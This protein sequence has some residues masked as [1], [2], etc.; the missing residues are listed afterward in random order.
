MTADQDLLS[1]YVRGRRDAF[2][3]LWDRHG[4]RVFGVALRV[5]GDRLVA[6]EVVQE[7]FCLL[8][9][10]AAVLAGHPSP[11]GWLHRTA[12]N[13]AR[14]LRRRRIH[15]ERKLARFAAE[16]ALA[17]IPG[18]APEPAEIDFAIS[19]LPAD[20][21]D[22]VVQRFYDGADYA[23]IGD[24]LGIS[25]AAARKRLSRALRRLQRII[26]PRKAA[27]LSVTAP[28]VA[29]PPALE[30]AV[31]SQAAAGA[32]PA[33]TLT[34]LT[35]LM[36]SKPIAATAAALI[37]TGGLTWFSIGTYRENR[38][39]RAV[40]EQQAAESAGTSR[41]A[42][43]GGDVAAGPDGDGSSAAQLAAVRAELEEERTRRE[44][45]ERQVGDLRRVADDLSDEVVVSFGRVTDIGNTLGSAFTEAMALRDLEEKGQLDTPENQIRFGKFFRSALSISGLSQELIEFEDNPEEGSRFVGAVYGTVFGLSDSERARVES[46]FQELLAEAAERELTLSHLP[47]PGTEEFGPWMER[48]WEFFNGHRDALRELLP[49]GSHASFDKWV[50]KG[51]YGFRNLK[52]KGMPFMFSLGG[53]PR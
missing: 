15:H 38:R 4:G 36:T 41:H 21:R 40:L 47:E 46:S 35:T 27:A 49:A 48:R 17:E 34:T 29:P 42:T 14:M 33:G 11:A 26:G 51:G 31:L 23:I 43:R 22:V 8:A 44:A 10:K 52:I 24:R 19:R 30:A 28:A 39:L 25:E 1:E 3:E 20:E 18:I 37:L 9:R 50:E 16:P 45:L 6:E 32:A 13:T 7:V 5:T 53:D 2:R 12:V